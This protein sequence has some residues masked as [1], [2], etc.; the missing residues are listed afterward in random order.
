[1]RGTS[2][3]YSSHNRGNYIHDHFIAQ[4]A[5]RGNGSIL[6]LPMSETVQNGSEMERQEFSWG[7]FRWFF[8]RYRGYGLNAFPFYWSSGLKKS[9]VDSLWH[10]LWSAEVVILGGGHSL[11]GMRRYKQLGAQFDGEWGKF[12]RLL[13]ERRERGL[14]TVGFSAG[15][16]QLGDSLFRRTWGDE[17][18]GKGFGLVRSTMATLHHEPSRNGD[19]AE[20]AR[21]FPGNLVFGLPNDSGINHDWGR[22]PSGNIWQASEFIIDNSWDM[23]SDGFHIKTRQG[24]KIDHMYSDGRHWSFG[25]GDMLVRVES[26]DGR[27]R[28]T[29]MR[30]G[31]SWIHYQSQR[32]SSFSSVQQILAAH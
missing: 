10:W 8:D 28:E 12:G 3:I 25:G 26:P 7:T 17:Y 29:W 1:M 20:A 31:G 24:A 19:L 14:L 23:P 22:L 6:F 5:L 9:D 16:D 2:L 21:K 18:D 32:P 13:H 27:W 4:R 30:S 11:T 15:A